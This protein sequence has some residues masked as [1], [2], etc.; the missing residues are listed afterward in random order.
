MNP[1]NPRIETAHLLLLNRAASTPGA[2]R[3]ASGMV[4]APERLMSAAEMTKTAAA[5]LETDWLLREAD[6]TPTF[7][8]SPRLSSGHA[9]SSTLA[10]LAREVVTSIPA[11]I[12]QR[13]ENLCMSVPAKHVTF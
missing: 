11:R 10:A 4:K 9:C 12:A 6:S 3:S 13:I 5:V 2:R 1:L 8:K 7:I